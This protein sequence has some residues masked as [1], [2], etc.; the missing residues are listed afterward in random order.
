MT[1]VLPTGY[2]IYGKSLIFQ[3]SVLVEERKKK[4]TR[5]SHHQSF[6]ED[7]IEEAKPK[8]LSMRSVY[9]EHRGHKIREISFD[10]R[11]GQKRS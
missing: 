7:Q 6:I 3:L 2:I 1:L 4:R 11:I 5:Y 9:R 8:D 10:I